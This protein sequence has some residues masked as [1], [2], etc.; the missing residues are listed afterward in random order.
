MNKE[1]NIDNSNNVSLL[2]LESAMMHLQ[3]TNKRL[4]RITIVAL[5]LM[6]LMFGFFVYL[7]TSFEITTEDVVVD[8]D[9]GNANYIGNDGDIVNGSGQ[10]EEDN[11]Q[12]EK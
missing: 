6:G 10:G 12:E 7:F 3:Q 9:N 1:N 4:A 2:M 5:I 8:S 11:D